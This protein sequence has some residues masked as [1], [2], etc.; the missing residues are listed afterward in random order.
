MGGMSRS[1]GERSSC[2]SMSMIGPKQCWRKAK[3]TMFDPHRSQ[4]RVT[5]SVFAS[6]Y[7]ILALLPGDTTPQAIIA[8]DAPEHSPAL[9]PDGRWLAYVSQE[10]GES[11]VYV[12]RFPSGT[13]RRRVTTNPGR[14]PLWRQDGR[15]LFFR[16][17]IGE[18]EGGSCGLLL[19]A[20]VRRSISVHPSHSSSSRTRL[21]PASPAHSAMWARRIRRVR[22]RTILDGV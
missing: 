22:R 20:R 17:R 10:S 14:E 3:A 18:N 7:N 12:V 13:G 9:S 15:A 1:V 5:P 4:L 16:E 19:L 2:S 8:T 21:H 6:G 11:H